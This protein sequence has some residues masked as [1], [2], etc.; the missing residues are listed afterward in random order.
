MCY[1]HPETAYS[2]PSRICNCLSCKPSV[3]LQASQGVSQNGGATKVRPLIV[4]AL[5]GQISKIAMVENASGSLLCLNV[6]IVIVISASI[7]LFHILLA[8]RLLFSSLIAFP[9]F[10]SLL[11][12]PHD[13][14]SVLHLHSFFFFYSPLLLSSAKL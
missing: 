12:S 14:F 1:F 9:H 7:Y 13:F 8:F 5:K 2:Y 4:L 11:L 6:T 10:S 3:R